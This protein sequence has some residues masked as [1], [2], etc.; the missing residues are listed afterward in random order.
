MKEQAHLMFRFPTSCRLCH[1][2]QI[3][4]KATNTT[5]HKTLT[6]KLLRKTN[7]YNEQ[8]RSS[9]PYIQKNSLKNNI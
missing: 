9:Y 1:M 2:A 3:L 7:S 8:F 4:F 5:L 6:P